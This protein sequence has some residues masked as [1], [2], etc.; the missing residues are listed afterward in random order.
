MCTKNQN[1]IM[2]YNSWDTEW[3][4]RKI[5]YFRAIFCSFISHL[6]I[7]NIKISKKKKKRK[8]KKTSLEI[9]SCYTF[10]FTINEDHMIFGSWKVRCNRQKFLTF[11]VIFCRFNSLT[12]W[13][14]KILILKKKTPGDI[15][16]LN[17]CTINKNH[18]MY[19]SWEI[20]HKRHNFKKSKFSKEWKT[21]LKIL[22]FYKHKW[23][24]YNVWFLRYGVQ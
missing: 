23:Q 13:K 6:K 8:K 21:H 17:I 15:I 10:M 24:S 4:K 5:L 7:P 12:I 9:L 19:G 18:M 11:L 20:E 22:S 1:H 2:V 3:N 16:I 14:I